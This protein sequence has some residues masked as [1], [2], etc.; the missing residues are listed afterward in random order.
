MENVEDNSSS[1]ESREWVNTIAEGIP[2]SS[3][4]GHSATLIGKSVVIFGGHYYSD[5]KTGFV[6]LNDTFCLDVALSKWLKPYCIGKIPPPRYGHSA[7][8]AG[9]IVVV[10]GGKGKSSVFNDLYTFDPDPEK[11]TWLLANETGE[12]PSPRFNHSASLWNKKMYIFGG[13]NGR[14]Y[15]NDTLTFDLEKMIWSRLETSGTTPVAR[16]GHASCVVG[17]N[18]IIQGGF[19]YDDIEYKKQSEN[20]GTSLRVIIF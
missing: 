18:L 14:D 10:F 7:I 17:H 8:F 11:Y 15:F 16:Q 19:S 6:Y 20:Y 2:P 1:E 12:A 9:G 5:K 13:W 3:R 4:G